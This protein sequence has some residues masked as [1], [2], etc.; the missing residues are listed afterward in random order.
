M[1]NLIKVLIDFIVI[2]VSI[3]LLFT[4]F[5]FVF[6]VIKIIQYLKWLHANND[7]NNNK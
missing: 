3:G 1:D 5:G 4:I 6:V 2:V 7:K